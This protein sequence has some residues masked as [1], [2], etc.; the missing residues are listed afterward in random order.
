MDGIGEEYASHRPRS[1]KLECELLE[2]ARIAAK[3]QAD[4]ERAAQPTSD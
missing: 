1:M 4:Y 3:Y 2:G